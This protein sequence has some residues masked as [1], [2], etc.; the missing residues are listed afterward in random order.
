MLLS[1]GTSERTGARCRTPRLTSSC[2]TSPW[3]GGVGPGWG[4]QYGYEDLTL[5]LCGICGP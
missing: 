4:S 2:R 3:T 1:N 5:G